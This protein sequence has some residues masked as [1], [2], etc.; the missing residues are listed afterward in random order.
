MEDRRVFWARKFAEYGSALR[1]YFRRR[2]DKSEDVEDLA[3]EVYLRLLRVDA[4]ES[5]KIAN[6]EAYLYT[7]AVN[8][9]RERAV[10]RKRRGRDLDI[11]DVIDELFSPDPTPEEQAV[12]VEREARLSSVIKD[13]SPKF[14]A[15]LVMH[16]GHDLSHQE[17]ADRL[18]I[19]VHAVKKNISRGLQACRHKMN[20]F[21]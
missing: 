9:L 17:I 1:G 15:A 12:R 14:R 13:L 20:K 6:P 11:L 3:Q 19:S 21:G 18:G 7:V 16:Y 4:G 10:L 5:S 8:L 2:A